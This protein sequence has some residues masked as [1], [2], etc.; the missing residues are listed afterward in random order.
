MAWRPLQHEPL[1]RFSK[2]ISPYKFTFAVHPLISHKLVGCKKIA[3]RRRPKRFKDVS[4]HKRPV[5]N[6]AIIEHHCG[7]KLV[8]GGGTKWTLPLG[9]FAETF[10]LPQSLVPCS[11]RTCHGVTGVLKEKDVLELQ[12]VDFLVDY[13]HFCKLQSSLGLALLE[14]ATSS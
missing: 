8:L 6:S 2:P 4:H 14:D 10:P 3:Q 7:A 5:W 9:S 1:W 13:L 12:R 11:C